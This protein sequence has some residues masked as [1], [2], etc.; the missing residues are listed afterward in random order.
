MNT[1][2]INDSLL[3]VARIMMSII[4]LN[5]GY[6]K[7]MNF[8]GTSAY[9]AAKGMPLVSLFLVGAIV[10][11][12]G[13]GLSLLLGLKA[14]WGALS[15]FLFLIPTTLIFH[16][17]WGLEASEAAMQQIHFLKNLTIMGGLLAVAA[18]GARQPGLGSLCGG[19]CCSCK[20][21]SADT[22]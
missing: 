13:G 5:S 16:K 2:K 15:L 1:T 11:E 9:M 6:G 17:F 22:Q 21:E 18:A 8:E 12:I 10:V 7:I 14:R 4:F 20:T 19:C 3:V